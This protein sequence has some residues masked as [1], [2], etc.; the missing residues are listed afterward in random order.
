MQLYTVFKLWTKH[1]VDKLW[2]EGLFE[3]TYNYFLLVIGLIWVI[4]VLVYDNLL[5]LY[6]L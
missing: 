4:F 2:Q 6:L 1:N 5:L 3:R